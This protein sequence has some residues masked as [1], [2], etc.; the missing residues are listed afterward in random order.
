MT[1]RTTAE[2]R[3]RHELPLVD[4]AALA[5]A[6]HAD[7]LLAA[8]QAGGHARWAT[9]MEPIPGR[10][11]DDPPAELRAV[12]RRAR[13]AFGPKDSIRDVLPDELALPFRD[14]ID[15]VLAVLARAEADRA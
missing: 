6:R 2:S 13:A 14:S 8:A 7:R 4:E 1:R 15:R 12:A 3:P 9:F 10:L 11:R 5:A